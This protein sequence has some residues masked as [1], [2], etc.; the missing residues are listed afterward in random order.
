MQDSKSEVAVVNIELFAYY[1]TRD[2]WDNV[3]LVAWTLTQN[4]E[5]LN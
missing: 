2:W 3:D 5:H 4:M 1:G